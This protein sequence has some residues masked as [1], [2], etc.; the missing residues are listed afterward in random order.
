MG[1]LS[2]LVLYTVLEWSCSFLSIA[3]DLLCVRACVL[4]RFSPVRLFVTFWT[5]ACQV[6]LS[7]GFSKQEYWSRL[8]H[9]PLGDLPDPGTKPTSLMSLA[10]GGGVLANS[11]T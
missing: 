7:M 11:A 2:V 6:L 10:L 8:P 1:K 9:S 5:V 3:M 4:N